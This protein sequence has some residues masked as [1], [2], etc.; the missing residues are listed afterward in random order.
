VDRDRP[1]PLFNHYLE[2]LLGRYRVLEHVERH[3]SEEVVFPALAEGDVLVE[4][5]LHA[6]VH[7]RK[8]P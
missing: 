4:R 7:G 1:K 6:G 3:V 2:V 5:N 8:R